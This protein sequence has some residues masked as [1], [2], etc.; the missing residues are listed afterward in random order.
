MGKLNIIKKKEI[1]SNHFDIYFNNG[2]MAFVYINNQQLCINSVKINGVT[3]YNESNQIFKDVCNYFAEIGEK[4][5]V[6]SSLIDTIY[7]NV[8]LYKLLK[9]SCKLYNNFISL[10]DIIDNT[11]DLNQLE[12]IKQIA[13]E[14]H[15]RG[16]LDD[17]QFIL[18]QTNINQKIK[19]IDYLV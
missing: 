14:D 3:Y 1:L 7:M 6:Y 8:A 15:E 17:M 18:S 13:V 9:V 4:R 19:C 11:W 5:F 16:T 10:L 12:I 2:A